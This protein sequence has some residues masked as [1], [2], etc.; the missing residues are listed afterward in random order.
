MVVLEAV[1]LVIHKYDF[2]C[3]S[4]L[5]RVQQEVVLESFIGQFWRP[6]SDLCLAYEGN[7][8]FTN[9]Y[10]LTWII[11]SFKLLLQDRDDWPNFVQSIKGSIVHDQYRNIWITKME[12]PFQL[13]EPVLVKVVVIPGI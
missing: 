3:R 5:V 6:H 7:H 2:P 10:F 4:K 13:F 11:Q 1:F 12:I 9:C 8:V